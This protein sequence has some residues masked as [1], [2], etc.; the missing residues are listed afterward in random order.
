MRVE[1]A[2]LGL[3][4]VPDDDLHL[5]VGDA[6]GGV[7]VP[8]HLTTRELVQDVE[9]SLA[10]DGVYAANLID[11]PPLAF[12]RAEVA[13][14]G[15][16]FDHVVLAAAPAT[17]RGAGGGNLVVVASQAPVDPAA[18]QAAIDARDLDWEVIDGSTLEAWVGDAAVLTDDF[19]PVDQ[20]LTPY[21][22]AVV[23]G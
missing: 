3:R 21:P 20:L 1:D 18:W 14:L 4:D 6:F 13:T 2:R 11:F 10:A 5:V 9:R 12:A 7:S 17:V 16:V 19:A 15:T 23:R 8:W 22:P